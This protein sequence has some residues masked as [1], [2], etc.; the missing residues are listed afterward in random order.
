VVLTLA[1]LLRDVY[2]DQKFHFFLDNLFLTVSMAQALLFLDILCTG[3][4]R[5]NAAGVPEKL[6][7]LK[8]KNQTLIWNS[9]FSEIMNG[10]NCFLWQDNNAVLGITTAYCLHQVVQRWRK[11]PSETLT[12]ARI[13]RPVFG[14]AVRKFLWIPKVIDEYNHNMNGVDHANQLRSTMTVNRRLEHRI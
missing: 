3:T 9:A 5:K 1:Q 7:K 8:K 6:I 13:V 12:N 2:S 4:T 14:D 11:R 10:I